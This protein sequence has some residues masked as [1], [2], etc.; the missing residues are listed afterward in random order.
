MT[1]DVQ[2]APAASPHLALREPGVWLSV[3][4]LALII[5]WALWPGLM[6]PGDPLAVAPVNRL[7]PPSFDNWFGT[8]E[9]GRDVFTRVVHGT[10]LSMRATLIAVLIG[11]GAGTVL[12]VI[13]GFIGGIA[14][15]IVMWLIDIV[16]AIPGL[17]LS[18]AVIA[19]LG[20]G[21][22]QVAIAVGSGSIPTFARVVRA[23]TLR[24]RTQD[25]VEA[26]YAMGAGHFRT[27]VHHVVPNILA[28]VGVLAAATLGGAILAVSSLSFLGFGIAPPA[29]EWGNLVSQGRNFIHV[30]WW[31]TLLPAAVI[32]ATVL[33]ANRL[34]RALD[35]ERSRR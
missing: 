2:A 30:A 28:Q 11:M 4:V 22:L 10:A 7:K 19:A 17:L 23:E 8:D 15:G 25:F 21:P 34:S 13:A 31:L 32:V 35:P 27:L 24:V 1:D 12:G 6:A 5:V 14:D 16:L 33:A 20:P 26:S 9:L 18:L 3:A 29:P